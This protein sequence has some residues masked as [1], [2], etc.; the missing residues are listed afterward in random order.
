MM[1]LNHHI[2]PTGKLCGGPHGDIYL[3]EEK[4]LLIRRRKSGVFSQ[5]IQVKWIAPLMLHV[6]LL[7]LSCAGVADE[8]L[9]QVF[10]AIGFK[11]MGIFIYTE[12]QTNLIKRR[13][14]LKK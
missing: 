8:I 13:N 6:I 5:K 2:N 10:Y 4:S 1:P 3:Q 9:V 7:K 11:P 12:R 14:K